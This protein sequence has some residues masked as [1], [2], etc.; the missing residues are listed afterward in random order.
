MSDKV[1]TKNNEVE[2]TRRTNES[3]LNELLCVLDGEPRPYGVTDN[4]DLCEFCMEADA[5]GT[6]SAQL[7]S[8]GT[9]KYC[10][11]GYWRE[12]T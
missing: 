10:E 2:A 9:F 5:G 1:D 12:D 7:M 11:K 4:C 6:F 8:R 3:E